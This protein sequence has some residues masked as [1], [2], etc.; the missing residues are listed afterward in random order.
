MKCIACPGETIVTTTYQN[1]DGITRR[2]RECEQCLFRF[3]TRE[4]PADGEVDRAKTWERPRHLSSRAKP[5]PLD[6]LSQAWYNRPSTTIEDKKHDTNS[7]QPRTKN[8]V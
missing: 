8:R 5:R 7:L 3:T 6:T 1:L 4:Y 2:R